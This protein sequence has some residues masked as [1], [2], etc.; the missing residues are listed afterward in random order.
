MWKV[1]FDLT[2]SNYAIG[3]TQFKLVMW[4]ILWIIDSTYKGFEKPCMVC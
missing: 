1:R 3:K 4:K 2:M